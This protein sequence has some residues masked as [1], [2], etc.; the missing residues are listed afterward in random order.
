MR[1]FLWL[2]FL[3]GVVYPL[4]ITVIAQTLFPTQANG[5]PTLIAQPFV[6]DKYFWPRPS[7]VGYNALASGG[8]NLSP[9]SPVLKELAEKHK[10]LPDELIY[11]SASGLDP[12]LSYEAA[13]FQVERVAKARGL[14]PEKVVELLENKPLVNVLELNHKLDGLTHG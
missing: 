12:H 3:V 14:P 11:S 10:G 4:F 13:F 7:A 5:S 1:M 2:T 8:S 6:S 9:T